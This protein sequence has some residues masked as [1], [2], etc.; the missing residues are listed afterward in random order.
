MLLNHVYAKNTDSM[1]TNLHV[2]LESWLYSPGISHET[3][4]SNIQKYFF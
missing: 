4:R 3:I 2:R 1:S